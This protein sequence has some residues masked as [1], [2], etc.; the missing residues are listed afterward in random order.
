MGCLFMLNAQYI[1]GI[2]LTFN[3]KK[4]KFGDEKIKRRF[5]AVLFVFGGGE[6]N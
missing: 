4:R 2:L 1:M 5:Y 6:G 3:L